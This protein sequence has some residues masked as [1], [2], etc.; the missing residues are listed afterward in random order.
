MRVLM[1]EDNDEVVDVIVSALE[2]AGVAVELSR[3]ATR[4][5]AEDLIVGESEFDLGIFDLKIPSDHGVPDEDPSYGRAMF[6]LAAEQRPGMLSWVL[7]GFADEDFLEELIGD[8]RTGDVFGTG[9]PQSLVAC[10]RK[11]NLAKMVEAVV[12]VGKQ[13]NDLGLVDLS[14]GG[15]VVELSGDEQKLLRIILRRHGASVGQLKEFKPGLSGSRA[16]HVRGIGDQGQQVLNCVVKVGPRDSLLEEEKR[17]T[18]GVSGV[19]PAGCFA[20][21][22]EA[23]H[24]GAG[25]RSLLCYSL[26]GA[27][28]VSLLDLAVE[29]EDRAIDVLRELRS[30]LA[31]WIDGGF[32]ETVQPAVLMG[33]LGAGPLDDLA[34]ERRPECDDD[35]LAALMNRAL[36]VRTCTQHGDLHLGNVLVGPGDRPILIDFGRTTSRIAPYDAVVLE[37]SSF[38]HPDGR[39]IFGD[40][41]SAEQAGSFDD[42]DTYLLDCPSPNFVQACRMWAHESAV[43]DREV[44]LAALAVALRQLRF[45]DP[46]ER[47][48]AVATRAIELLTT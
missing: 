22:S 35:R 3:A 14:T 8:P 45:P 28:P 20:P 25:A 16:F 38:F 36:P 2:K 10:H 19:L 4:T 46:P 33:R 31:V 41:P 39:E 5:E 29:S 27:D 1:V 42:L 15:K 9:T 18:D 6:Y 7:S 17:F 24:F 37:L 26:A 21:L 48:R 23:L 44:W 43:S 32:V 13:L 30:H 11:K 40:W 12:G 47:A 34:P